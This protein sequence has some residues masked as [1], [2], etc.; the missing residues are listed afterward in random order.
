MYTQALIGY[1]CIGSLAS[2]R[3]GKVVGD[4]DLCI[5]T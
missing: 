3:Q 2:F 1:F 4:G 5:F